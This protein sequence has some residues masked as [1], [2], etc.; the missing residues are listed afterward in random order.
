MVGAVLRDDL[1]FIRAMRS[2]PSRD[3]APFKGTLV[4]A[5]CA[6]M[7]TQGLFE[8]AEV[9]SFPFLSKYIGPGITFGNPADQ[10][11]KEARTVYGNSCQISVILS[12]GTGAVGALS[13]EVL[14]A[15]VGPSN[16]LSHIAFHCDATA[17]NLASQLESVDGYLRLN[18]EQGATGWTDANWLQPGNIATDTDVHMERPMINSSVERSVE[19]LRDRKPTATVGQLTSRTYTTLSQ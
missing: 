8:P 12:L 15:P 11:L 1:S 5:A 16:I 19:L 10:I 2:Y 4:E 18:V 14:S 17:R 6:T 7:A 13:Q 3:S 9:G